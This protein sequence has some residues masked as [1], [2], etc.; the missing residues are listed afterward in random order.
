MQ[1]TDVMRRLEQ[2]GDEQTRKTYRRHGADGALFG[3]RWSELYALQKQ[4]GVD[5]PLALALWETG[6]HDARTLATLVADPSACTAAQ[7]DAWQA[8]CSYPAINGA[9]STLA[10]RSPLAPTLGARWRKAKADL[11]SAAGWDVIGTLCA[12]GSA[13]DD[14]WL[15]P[16]LQEI[17]TGIARAPNRTRYAMNNALISMGGYR[18]ALRDEALAIAREIGKV[19]VDHGDTSCKTP[20]AA[21]YIEKMAVRHSR[22]AA[23]SN[24]ARAKEAASAEKTAAKKTAAKK[25]AAK[26]PA[27][28]KTA[29]KKTAAKKTAAKKPTAKKPA[30]KKTAAKKTAAKKTAA[31]KP[32]AKKPVAKKTA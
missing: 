4:I 7:L 19:E 8:A 16:L 17:R 1:P 27:A 13:V 12:P 5:H 28:K 25:A 2:L 23:K 6:N 32:A 30:A 26:K 22:K 9:V 29:A 31:K 3:V 14:A 21:S 15:R 18:P 10:A 11:R 24:A 20:D